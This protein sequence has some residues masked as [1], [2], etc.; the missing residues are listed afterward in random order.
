MDINRIQGFLTEENKKKNFDRIQVNF[1]INTFQGN[2]AQRF[3]ILDVRSFLIASQHIQVK[4]EKE[5]EGI[6][7]E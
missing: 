1:D 6:F 4:I 7:Y 3:D 2:Q 5:L